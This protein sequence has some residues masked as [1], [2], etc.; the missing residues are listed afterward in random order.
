MGGNT[1][2]RLQISMDFSKTVD[3]LQTAGNLSHNGPHGQAVW[4]I[5]FPTWFKILRAK[6]C[7]ITS[8]D[9]IPQVHLTQIHIKGILLNGKWLTFF[10]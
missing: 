7:H 9:E 5:T 2:M 4:E 1:I 6:S 3:M 10:S 8:N